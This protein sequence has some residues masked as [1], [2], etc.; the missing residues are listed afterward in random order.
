MDITI[1]E[2]FEQLAL[3]FAVFLRI[4]PA[5]AL[6]PGYGESSTPARV[7]LAIAFF[8]SAAMVP[9]VENKLPGQDLTYDQMVRFLLAETVFGFF[10]G[11]VSRGIL[12]LLEQAGVVI[13][14]VVSL[15]QLVG[16]ATALLPVIGHVLTVTGLAIIMSGPLGKQIILA[17]VVSYELSVGSLPLILHAIAEIGSKIVNFVFVNGVALAGSFLVLFFVYY[18]FT[19]FVNKA[20]PQF[21]VSFVG[22]PFVALL[23]IYYLH[24]NSELILTVW[25]E[26]SLSILMMPFEALK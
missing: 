8:L 11:I 16:N 24:R 6:T 4:G 25:Q 20:M 22:I 23:S 13:S 7:K 3:T 9:I 26:K 18:L 14:Q 15:A 12:L 2:I 1:S 21:M 17:F 10:L 19:G 5:I